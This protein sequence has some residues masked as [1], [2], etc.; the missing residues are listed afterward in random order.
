M[1]SLLYILLLLHF[2]MFSQDK[3]V[4]AEVI[5]DNEINILFVSP[6]SFPQVS[7]VFEA[8]KNNLPI[9]NLNKSSIEVYED[10]KP[11]DVIN[12]TSVTQNQP[13]F[14]SMIIDHSGSMQYD[15]IQLIDSNTGQFFKSV[16]VN[17]YGQIIKYP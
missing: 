9:F 3:I 16:I 4:N 12:L 17:E 8:L 6:D 1:K 2:S 11:C 13:F 10:D 5:S 7:I 14:I 15:P